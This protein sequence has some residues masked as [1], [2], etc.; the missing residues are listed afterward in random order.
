M[1]TLSTTLAKRLEDPRLFR[2]AADPDPV[3]LR[4]FDHHRMKRHRVVI[5]HGL[6]A[7]LAVRPKR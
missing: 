7:Q 6:D 1:T 4:L 3:G 5:L 2:Q